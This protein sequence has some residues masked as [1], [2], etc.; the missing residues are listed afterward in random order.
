MHDGSG[1]ASRNH[2]FSI[3]VRQNLIYRFIKFIVGLLQHGIR[4]LFV[5]REE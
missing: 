3:R 4:R 5:D 1:R 2:A